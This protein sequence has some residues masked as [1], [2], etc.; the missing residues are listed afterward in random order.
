MAEL[1]DLDEKLDTLPLP[2]PFSVKGAAVLEL[3]LK[4]L[5]MDIIHNIEVVEFLQENL[6]K[7]TDSWLWQKQL[8]WVE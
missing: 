6:V 2:F 4:A 1:W 5:I 3:K 8:R 7:S